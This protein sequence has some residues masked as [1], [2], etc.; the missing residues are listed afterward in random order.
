MSMY[1]VFHSDCY[2]N[3]RTVQSL[4]DST[5]VNRIL[6]RHGGIK[7]INHLQE[8]GGEYGD[9]THWDD[10]LTAHQQLQRGQ[11]IFDNL[12]TELRR[13]FKNEPKEF[14]SFVNQAELAGKLHEVFPALAQPGNQVP[15]VQRTLANKVATSTPNPPKADVSEA[16]PTP[17]DQE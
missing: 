8:F 16:Q 17:S 15:V 5:D 12:P 9:F 3:C 13:E 11:E 2:E 14:F 10:L 4:K 1:P 6:E 7:S